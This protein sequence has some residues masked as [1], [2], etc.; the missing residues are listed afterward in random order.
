MIKNTIIISQGEIC[1]WHIVKQ[2]QCLFIGAHKSRQCTLPWFY[3]G[4]IEVY[5][6]RF[7][8]SLIIDNLHQDLCR[9]VLFFNEST[10]LEY[11]LGVPLFWRNT[12]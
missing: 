10:S 9:H 2:L 6:F 8:V 5:L 4:L 1:V 7:F 11:A 3:L 12:L